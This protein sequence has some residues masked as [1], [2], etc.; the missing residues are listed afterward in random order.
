[1]QDSEVEMVAGMLPEGVAPKE[2]KKIRR[3]KNEKVVEEGI[4]GRKLVKETHLD[5]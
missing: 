3:W 5:T 4:K 1:M 2:D